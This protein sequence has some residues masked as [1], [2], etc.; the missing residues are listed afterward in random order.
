MSNFMLFYKVT[1]TRYNGQFELIFC[2]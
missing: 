2:N 1:L